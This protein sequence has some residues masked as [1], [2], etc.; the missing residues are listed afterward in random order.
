MVKEVIGGVG[1]ILLKL[2]NEKGIRVEQIV[3]FGSQAQTS[4]PAESDIDLIVVSD[5]FRNDDIFLRS[6]KTRGIHRQ[7]VRHTGM[8]FDLLY[9]SSLEWRAARSPLLK[10]AKAHGHMLYQRVNKERRRSGL[11]V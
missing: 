5:D 7:L 6:R 2:L 9:C 10:E 3:L 11:S 4:P 8:P 1:K